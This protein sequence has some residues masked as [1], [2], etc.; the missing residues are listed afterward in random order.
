MRCPIE[1]YDRPAEKK[2]EVADAL[3]AG[4]P[5]IASNIAGFDDVMTNEKEG[6]LIDT[7]DARGFADAI[8]RVAAKAYERHLAQ[9]KT[10]TKGPA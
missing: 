1:V 4:I 9:K 5:V 8:L 3:D 7:G 2:L 10:A 6:L